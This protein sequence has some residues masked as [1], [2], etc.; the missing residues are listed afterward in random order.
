MEENK[1][2]EPVEIDEKEPVQEPKRPLAHKHLWAIAVLLCIAAIGAGTYLTYSAYKAGDFLKAVAAT[3][4]SQALFT[5]DLLNEYTSTHAAIAAKSIVVDSSGDTCTFTFRIYNCLLDN[6]N[7]FNDKDVNAILAVT[8]EG[9]GTDGE[10]SVSGGKTQ[11]LEFQGYQA[12]VKTFTVTF[13]Q[14]YLDKA[15]F[16]IMAT[17]VPKT[18]P[19]TNLAM[20]AATIVPNRRADV[21]NASVQYDWVDKGGNVGNYDAYNFRV[22]VTGKAT[23]VTLTWGDGVEL[24]PFFSV[25]HGNVAVDND[26]RTVTFN[27]EPGSEIINF[28]RKDGSIAPTSWD[29]IGAKA[30]AAN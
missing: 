7:V 10:W 27:M 22:T 11:D 16:T 28:Y 12:V 25:N 5:S 18:S 17:V 6:K 1:N 29:A 21:T 14:V 13:K 20:L 19:G 2:I 23:D 9:A 15:K 8:A 30:T 26:N 24:D 3:T 4:T